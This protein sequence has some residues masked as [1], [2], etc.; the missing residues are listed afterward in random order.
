MQTTTLITHTNNGK[1]IRCYEW[2]PEHNGGFA[3]DFVDMRGHYGLGKSGQNLTAAQLSDLRRRGCPLPAPVCDS[4]KADYTPQYC[5]DSGNLASGET[6]GG[7]SGGPEAKDSEWT[8]AEAVMGGDTSGDTDWDNDSMASNLRNDIFGD[9]TTDYDG[10]NESS[11]SASTSQGDTTNNNNGTPK[12]KAPAN[13]N[14]QANNNNAPND[15]SSET[16]AT[17]IPYT[18]DN[19]FAANFAGRLDLKGNASCTG[20]VC[21]FTTKDGM[22]WKITDNFN[23]SKKN[24]IITIDINGE[25]KGANATYKTSNKP[26]IFSFAVDASGK[27]YVDNNDPIVKQYLGKRHG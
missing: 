21:S 5:Q 25:S 24:A 9:T 2:D 26:D 20:N 14:A 27:I 16:T 6:S 13:N 3:A 4:A 12:N 23:T 1:S 8:D 10:G 18:S 17:E 7:S 11:S 19:K 15:T 22:S